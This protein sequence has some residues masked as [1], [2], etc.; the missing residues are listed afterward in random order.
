VFLR[1]C[2]PDPRRHGRGMRRPCRGR[3][4]VGFT[5]I[6]LLVVIAI[7]AVLIGL[8]LPAVQKV[9]EAA[10]RMACTN[11]LKQIA[12]AMHNYESTHGLLPYATKADVLDA[13]H[14]LHLSLP[15][16]EQQTVYAL[17]TNLSG[18]V[19]QTG[20]WPGAHA[21]STAA[22]YRRARTTVLSVYQCPSDIPH[23]MNEPGLEYYER[24][25]GNYRG[26]VG[27]GDLY[28]NAPV[29]A[30]AG[31]AAGRGVFSVTIAQIFG[32]ANRPRQIK[33]TD[34][35]DG[36]SNTLM[37]SEGLKAS[38]EARSL[39]AGTMGDITL[40][41][42]GG[43]FFASFDTP[44]SS[45]ADRIWGPCPQ[46]QGDGQYRAPCVWLGGP[47]RPPGNHANNQRTARAAARSKHPGGVNAALAD[48]SVR[49]VSDAMSA[50]AWR[51]LGTIGQGET[52]GEF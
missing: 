39:W 46:Q 32:T 47:L 9:R 20:D 7:I 35:S 22:N 42:M 8:L 3:R 43:G 45:N 29:G 25:R 2:R 49:F 4:A 16:L 48:G 21:F 14:W 31:Y 52:A 6:E 40:G 23:A 13:Y 50:A 33:L 27:S 37:F 41:N 24:F 10:N 30:P 1:L 11:K 12:L 44:N 26:C 28:G 34:I 5:L 19:T 15:F 36:T 51:A 38:L 18:P 17:Y